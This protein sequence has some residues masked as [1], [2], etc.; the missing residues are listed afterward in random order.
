MF[1]DV[2]GDDNCGIYGLV[3]RTFSSVGGVAGSMLGCG[4]VLGIGTEIGP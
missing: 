2:D 1:V 4:C 3:H